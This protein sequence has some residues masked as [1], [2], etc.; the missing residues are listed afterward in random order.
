MSTAFYSLI[1]FCPDAARQEA[2][3]V[4]VV[5][6]DTASGYVGV[7]FTPS[8]DRLRKFFGNGVIDAEQLKLLGESVRLLIDREKSLFASVD[9]FR[10]LTERQANE[11]RFTPPRMVALG[12]PQSVLEA[13]FQRLVDVPPSDVEQRNW[14]AAHRNGTPSSPS[15]AELV[16]TG[17]DE[18]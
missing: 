12:H 9:H 17:Q 10:T 13:V 16:P 3:N 18:G 4:G 2:V 8:V 15:A 5:L 14:A 6:F 7:K 11:V 1:Q